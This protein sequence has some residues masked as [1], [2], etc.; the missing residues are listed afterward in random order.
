[1]SQKNPFAKAEN[2]RAKANDEMKRPLPADKPRKAELL[3]RKVKL[4]FSY[5]D[6]LMRGK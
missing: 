2:K 5:I 1:M 4:T 3:P 6:W